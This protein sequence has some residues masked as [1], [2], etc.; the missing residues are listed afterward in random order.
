M[1]WVVKCYDEDN[2]LIDEFDILNRTEP[3]AEREAMAQLPANCD[4]WSMVNKDLM[5]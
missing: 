4:D 2:V 5:D 1:D 3:E